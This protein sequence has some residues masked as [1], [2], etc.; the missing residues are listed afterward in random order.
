MN[1]LI[2]PKMMFDYAS[3]T[4]YSSVSGTGCQ[5]LVIYINQETIHKSFKK[6]FESLKQAFE[7]VCFQVHDTA[8][9]YR[10]LA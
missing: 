5:G 7:T 10:F 1:G 8:E 3:H 4:L 9:L 6:V 2:N